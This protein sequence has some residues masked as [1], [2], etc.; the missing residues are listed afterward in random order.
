MRLPLDAVA[1][2]GIRSETSDFLSAATRF[3]RQ[4][5]TGSSSTR[6]RRQAG[7]HGRSQVRPKIP[8]NTFESQLIMYASV[9]RPSAIRRMYCGTG[10]CAGQAY[11]QSTTLWKYSGSFMSVG[12]TARAPYPISLLPVCKRVCQ[13]G[14]P[15]QDNDSS[16][17]IDYLLRCIYIADQPLH[18]FAESI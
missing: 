5:A 9:Y 7:S 11:W 6:P 17:E 4:I 16:T 8:G 10:V 18:F 15:N 12:F 2:G 3:S 14:S 13:G 1:G